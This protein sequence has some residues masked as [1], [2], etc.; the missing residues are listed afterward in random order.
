MDEASRCLKLK[1]RVDSLQSKVDRAE[2]ALES[3]RQQL[4]KEF[5]CKTIKEARKELDRLK[6]ES[7]QLEQ[8]LKNG[9]DVF[10]REYGKILGDQ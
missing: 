6:E 3:L 8:E 7:E 1:E 9:L 5:G 10:E 4:E 2:G